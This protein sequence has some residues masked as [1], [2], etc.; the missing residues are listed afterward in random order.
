[1]SHTVRPIG[2]RIVVKRLS[3]Q[4]TRSGIIMPGVTKDL[5]KVGEVIHAGE[6]CTFAKVGDL[7]LFAQY[8]GVRLPVDPTFV[9]SDDYGDCLIMNEEDI[10]GRLDAKLEPVLS[11]ETN[12]IAKQEA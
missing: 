7:I 4:T 10:L 8:S 3:P 5:S 6:D 9:K 12:G 11:Q 2:Q 1:M